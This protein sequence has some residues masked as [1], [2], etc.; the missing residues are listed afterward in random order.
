MEVMSENYSLKNIWSNE[1]PHK[2]AC[3]TIVSYVDYENIRPSLK[4]AEPPI[5]WDWYGVK[6]SGV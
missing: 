2:H 4:F 5:K 3:Q 6:S 1:L